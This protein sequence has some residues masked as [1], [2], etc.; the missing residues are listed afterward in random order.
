MTPFSIVIATRNRCSTLIRT[1]LSV[2]YTKLRRLEGEIVVVDNGSTDNTIDAV[3]EL[4]TEKGSSISLVQELQPGVGRARNAGIRVSSSPTIAFTDDDCY[5][6]SEYLTRVSSLFEN[7]EFDYVAGR[8]SLYDPTDASIGV[9]SHRRFS[10]IPPGTFIPVGI[11]LGANMI[12][13]RKV[14]DAIGGFDEMLGPGTPWRCEDIDLATRA[15]MAGFTGATLPD[16][17]IEHHHGRKPGPELESLRR[18]NDRARGAYY[19]KLAIDYNAPK[20][21]QD[22]RRRRLHVFDPKSTISMWPET[23]QEIIGGAHYALRRL[24]RLLFA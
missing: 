5:I 15:S 24:K 3:E 13:K 20:C 8:V 14:L 21:L 16:L 22:W 18:L 17:T 11:F 1:L 12:F 2:D 19:T 9:T 10:L 4:Q 23:K 7:S 6:T